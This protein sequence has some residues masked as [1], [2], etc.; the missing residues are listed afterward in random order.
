MVQDKVDRSSASK[1]ALRRH[2]VQPKWRRLETRMSRLE[3]PLSPLHH[4]HPAVFRPLTD[5]RL[6][7]PARSTAALRDEHLNGGRSQRLLSGKCRTGR[8]CRTE[9][10]LHVHCFRRK[11]HIGKDGK[12]GTKDCA[13][14][15]ERSGR[16]GRWAGTLISSAAKTGQRWIAI[17]AFVALGRD[18]Y[19]CNA[20]K[21]HWIALHV[22]VC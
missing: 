17:A 15:Y 6:Q 16:V 7:C 1:Q 4:P 8:T 20:G 21:T 9:L 5:G 11:V 12:E 22:S 2:Q 18:F 10:C 14:A 3:I 19:L 13:S